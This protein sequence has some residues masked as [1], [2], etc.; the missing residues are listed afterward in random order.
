MGSRG[1][2][3]AG[4]VRGERKRCLELLE[5]SRFDLRLAQDAGEAGEV[6]PLVL[7]MLRSIQRQLK[8][9]IARLMRDEGCIQKPPTPPMI[10]VGPESRAPDVPR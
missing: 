5:R 10:K 6:S 2:E 4:E 1:P 9:A 8:L 3:A 7:A